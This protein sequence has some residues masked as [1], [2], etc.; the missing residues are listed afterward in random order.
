MIRNT[1]RSTNL[2]SCIKRSIYFH[3]FGRG[4]FLVYPKLW[5]FGVVFG[6]KKQVKHVLVMAQT[7]MHILTY[8][9]FPSKKLQ[10]SIDYLIH[11]Y[12]ILVII[13]FL[14]IVLF[15]M[16]WLV[17]MRCEAWEVHTTVTHKIINSRFLQFHIPKKLFCGF[18]FKIKH[19]LFFIAI[20][21]LTRRN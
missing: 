10:K 13:T 1:I 3:P 19:M 8:L 17:H 21:L 16:S 14:L 5:N 6:G 2:A 12:I 4:S 15:I 11:Y 9:W 7:L 18:I 20:S